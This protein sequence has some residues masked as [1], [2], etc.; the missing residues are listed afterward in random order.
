MALYVIS[1]FQGCSIW[2]QV[3]LIGWDWGKNCGICINSFLTD[4]VQE[5][6]NETIRP[7]GELH[8]VW[9]LFLLWW[10]YLQKD[11]CL[12]NKNPQ[13]GVTTRILEFPTILILSGFS[14]F[15]LK[16]LNR[17][18]YAIWISQF[19]IPKRLDSLEFE[20]EQLHLRNSVV[21]A[22]GS[23]NPIWPAFYW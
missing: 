9:C 20:T 8:F 7:T 13:Q 15:C 3:F 17:H 12:A 5:Q 11:P 23:L 22:L 19:Y 1:R 18:Q 6:Y 10:W 21:T 16:I 4:Y 2:S 14:W